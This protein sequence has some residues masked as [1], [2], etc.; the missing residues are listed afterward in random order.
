MKYFKGPMIVNQMKKYYR[1]AEQYKIFI[2]LGKSK[3]RF[4]SYFDINAFIHLSNNLTV[5]QYD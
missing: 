1:L 5:Y 4:Y 3:S 2:N